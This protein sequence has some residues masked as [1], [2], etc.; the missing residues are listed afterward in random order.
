MP[1]D[2]ES[3]WERTDNFVPAIPTAFEQ[4]PELTIFVEEN[5]TEQQREPDAGRILVF[6]KLYD[7]VSQEIT[8][9][10]KIFPNCQTEGDSGPVWG[11]GL[12]SQAL[13][14]G[15]LQDCGDIYLIQ[16]RTDSVERLVL[17][18]DQEGEPLEREI[19]LE[20]GDICVV[21]M[22]ASPADS[23]PVSFEGFYDRLRNTRDILLKSRVESEDY[24]T[25]FLLSLTLTTDATNIR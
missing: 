24:P 15:K 1:S 13:Q 11:L 3:L 22:L 16:R 12:R 2:A 18:Y 7:P 14:A 20:S 5:E 25:E 9:L 17:Y 6:L 23:G 8:D 10:G 4:E 19:V 21:E